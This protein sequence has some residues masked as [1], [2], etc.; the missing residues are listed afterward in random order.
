[1]CDIYFSETHFTNGMISSS[2]HYFASIVSSFFTA[3]MD[4]LKKHQCYKI[5]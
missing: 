5:P 4:P 2:I 3:E 1:M